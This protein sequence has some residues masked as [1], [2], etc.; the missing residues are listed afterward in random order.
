MWQLLHGFLL[1]FLCVVFLSRAAVWGSLDVTSPW[2]MVPHWDVGRR[3]YG[4]GR[5]LL[6]NLWR[7]TVLPSPVISSLFVTLV[8]LPSLS[9]VLYPFLGF[10]SFSFIL[11][12]SLLSVR[13]LCFATS[14]S[15]LVLLFFCLLLL[16][17]T[18]VVCLYGGIVSQR[19]QRMGNITATLKQNTTILSWGL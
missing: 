18:A 4:R 5:M 8:L 17:H 12:P 16:P 6:L 1:P 2:Q 19:M 14:R 15:L 7:C 13:L 11:P 10:L 3:I 9:A